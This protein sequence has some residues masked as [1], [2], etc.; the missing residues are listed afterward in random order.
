MQKRQKTSSA[1]SDPY[2]GSM[3]QY[4][5]NSGTVRSG[6]IQ[7]RPQQYSEQR[8]YVQPNQ[9]Q[10]Q[11]NNQ[12]QGRQTV[13]PNMVMGNSGIIH[14]QYTGDQ[15]QRAIQ[16]NGRVI[17]QQIQQPG[18]QPMQ[19]MMGYSAHQYST[20]QNQ[21]FQRQPSQVGSQSM[22]I[23]QVNQLSSRVGKPLQQDPRLYQSVNRGNP[24][25]H[26]QHQQQPK[27]SP[28]PPNQIR[29]E[30]SKQSYDHE[31]KSLFYHPNVLVSKM[32]ETQQKPKS[33]DLFKSSVHSISEHFVN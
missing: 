14:P 22:Q 10:L 6:T 16:M 27:F 12:Y 17:Q 1:M 2:R 18:K 3:P 23:Q 13:Y 19:T 8:M 24:Q 20:M 4:A 26:L 9:H 28:L 32:Q 29:V 15:Q 33:R 11:V 30:T 5:I 21:T 25:Q 31:A 7:N